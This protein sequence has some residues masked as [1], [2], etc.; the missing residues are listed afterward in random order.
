MNVDRKVTPLELAR[1]TP[2]PVSCLSEEEIRL[3]LAERCPKLVNL[4]HW[5]GCSLDADL[6]GW[7]QLRGTQWVSTV[8]NPQTPARQVFKLW[9]ELLDD[10][11]R[12]TRM[13][14]LEVLVFEH[15]FCQPGA[16][17][18]RL[19]DGMHFA[20]TL[21]VVRQ[22]IGTLLHHHALEVNWQRPTVF[23]RALRLAEVYLEA[24]VGDHELTKAG[25]RHQFTGRLGQGPVLLSRFEAVD[26]AS[27]SRSVELIRTSIADG[28]KVS[29][30]VPYLMEGL[31]R[32]HDVTDDRR[33]LGQVIEAHR[34]F[35]TARKSVAWRLHLAEAWLRLAD[36][37]PMDARTVGYLDEAAAALDATNGATGAE[38]VRRTILRT[39]VTQ[40]SQLPEAA[41]VRLALRGLPSQ[42]RFGQQVQRFVSADAPASTFPELV[43]SALNERFGNS[44]EPLIRRLLADWQR[45][46]AQFLDHSPQARVTLR[47]TVLDLLEGSQVGPALTD[48][49]S[50]MQYAD[51][52]LQLAALSGSSKHWSEG[53]VRLVSEACDD[54]STCVP[55]VVLGREAEICEVISPADQSALEARLAP[56]AGLHDAAAAWVRAL[57]ER[58]ADFF[59]ERAA[60]R[61]ITSP[62]VARRNLGGRS[63]V[64]TVED[65]LGFASSTLVFKP[66]NR[67]SVDRDTATAEA[68]KSALTRLEVGT[69]FRTSDMIT[70][71]SIDELSVASELQQDVDVITVRRFEH[72]RVLADLLSP[73][74]ESSSAELLKRAA[75]FLAY[76]HAA[77]RPGG[78]TPARPR[79]QIRGEVR[80][81][82]R[83]L[84]PKGADTLVNEAFDN[85]W[86]L[87]AGA[88]ALPRRDAHAFNWLVTD[89]GRIIAIDLEAV[90]QRPV[91]YEL[92]Q[93][94]DDV[95]ALLPQSWNLRREVLECYVEALRQCTGEP[96]DAA[97]VE[98]TWDV[99]RASLVIRAVRCL[100]DRTGSPSLR[101]HG[102]ALLDEVCSHPEWGAICQ[103]ALTL[104]DAWAERRGAS[105]G[106]P[107]RNLDTGRKRRISTALAYQ[108][109]HNPK[110][111]TNAQ[112]WA[113]VEDVLSALAGAGRPMSAA[114]LL[115]V[116]QALDEPRFEVWDDLIRARYGHTTSAP[117]D[118]EVKDPKQV[119]FHATASTNLFNIF[120]QRQGLRPMARKAVH[121]TTDPQTALL[122]GR[123]HGP[124]ILLAVENP[125]A[126]SLQ[127]RIAGGTT[128]L[129]DQVPPDAL[130]VVPL[131][132]LFSTH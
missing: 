1:R 68:V 107:L 89:D 24:V 81:W 42:F 125:V 40:A 115:T 20:K 43:L 65:H 88:P 112:G 93:L 100:T 92:A 63:N 72:G 111:P 130:S 6:P 61:A 86:A 124:A 28:N 39:I 58:D 32:L 73:E 96:Y 75:T 33:Y 48:A 114:E 97:E 123:R 23:C 30:A 118:H 41:T 109:R 11:E 13:N 91:G 113:R 117:D 26:S 85:W 121:L 116:A 101:Q 122:A 5:L 80:I 78:T 66:T 67:I 36:G 46:C 106:A 64:V 69:A 56:L 3:T 9:K 60:T 59:Y 54:P 70:V 2:P 51:D 16:A 19:P 49:L 95:P 62:D 10:T 7:V 99:Y 76:I 35:A 126:H 8:V 84:F 4:L 27:L 15:N 52:L 57:A 47:R 119:L 132:Q 110:L 29:D 14:L 129:I 77:P 12:T 38:T 17:A 74:T 45:A 55:L 102:E 105:G 22:W 131:H 120:Q 87:L 83:E 21:H 25:G 127:C 18:Q 50:R 103:V 31:L 37:R 94:T 79:G 44:G 90:G 98:R 53:V 128:W 82:L 104:R 108:L 71:L 34:E